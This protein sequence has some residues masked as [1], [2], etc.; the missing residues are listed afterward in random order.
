MYM[1]A[2]IMNYGTCGRGASKE[3]SKMS[4]KF[5]TDVPVCNEVI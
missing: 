4:G 5:V 2:Y 1:H 3:K